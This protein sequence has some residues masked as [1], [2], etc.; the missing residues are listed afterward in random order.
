M[1]LTSGGNRRQIEAVDDAVETASKTQKTTEPEGEEDAAKQSAK[2]E[3]T[4][5]TPRIAEGKV[6]DCQE[7]DNRKTRK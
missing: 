7:N 6:F 1:L 4:I 3:G 2:C 5:P